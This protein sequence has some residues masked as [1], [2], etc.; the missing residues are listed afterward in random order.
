MEDVA[1]MNASMQIIKDEE[2]HTKSADDVKIINSSTN[3]S[4]NTSH[5]SSSGEK[6]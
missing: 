6:K 5:R 3:A 1:D 2:N 4:G